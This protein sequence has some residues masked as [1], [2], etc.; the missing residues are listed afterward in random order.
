[1]VDPR[2][3]S[4][5]WIILSYC[6]LHPFAVL[7]N[8][9]RRRRRYSYRH[10]C[11]CCCH[12][13]SQPFVY[14][15]SFVFQINY[16]YFHCSYGANLLAKNPGDVDNNKSNCDRV[17]E[18]RLVDSYFLQLLLLFEFKKCL[19]FSENYKFKLVNAKR[20]WHF[21]RS[22]GN[23][24]TAHRIIIQNA[25][26][27]CKKRMTTTRHQMTGAKQMTKNKTTAGSYYLIVVEIARWWRSLNTTISRNLWECYRNFIHR[28]GKLTV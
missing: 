26:K 24:M 9:R 20:N 19:L 23:V 14:L 21:D 18:W 17:R 16:A 28:C 8:S 2:T 7:W 5:S 13:C 25:Y 12:V 4:D 3:A 22:I 1:M 15:S 27:R 10:C 11:C 6:L